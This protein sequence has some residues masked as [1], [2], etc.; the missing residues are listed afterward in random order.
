MRR[1]ELPDEQWEQIKEIFPEKAGGK[2]RPDRPSR[3][4]L[5]GIFWIHAVCDRKGLPLGAVLSSNARHD[6]GFLHNWQ[7]HNKTAPTALTIL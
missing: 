6:S 3:Q 2:G 4:I 1:Y 5:N 7:I